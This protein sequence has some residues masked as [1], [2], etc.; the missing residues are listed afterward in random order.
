ML[1]DLPSSASAVDFADN[2][3]NKYKVRLLQKLVL[4]PGEWEVVAMVAHVPDNFYNI[5]AGEVTL[6][7]RSSRV[8]QTDNVTLGFYQTPNSL[9]VGTRKATQQ[10][11]FDL[12]SGISDISEIQQDNKQI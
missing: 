7:S 4:E 9:L 11:R 10:W 2:T 12:R 8:Q 1:L 5:F 3:N 6:L